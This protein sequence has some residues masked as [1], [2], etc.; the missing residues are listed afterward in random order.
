[1]AG[2]QSLS[3]S[4]PRSFAR[5]SS[6][7]SRSSGATV[8]AAGERRA[9]LSAPMALVLAFAVA[10]PISILVTAA[11]MWGQPLFLLVALGAAACALGW[12]CDLAGSVLVGVVFWMFL[13]GFD[14]HHWGVL[15]WDGRT[16]AIR[17][18]VLVAAGVAGALA[19]YARDASRLHRWS[20]PDYTAGEEAGSSPASSGR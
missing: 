18:G 3:R 5:P 16:D 17:L 9:V 7:G 1:M 11:G 8:A 2:T 15:S 13:D 20:R 19:R 10:V 6:R 4:I 12:C 14:L